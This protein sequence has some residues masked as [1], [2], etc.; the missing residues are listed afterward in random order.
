MDYT[1]PP[2]GLSALLHVPAWWKAPRSLY[3]SCSALGPPGPT[4]LLDGGTH[5]PASPAA[6]LTQVQ[7]H[8]LHGLVLL[9][10]QVAVYAQA[11][12][13]G[14]HLLR[15][16]QWTLCGEATPLSLSLHS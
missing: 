15:V 7:Q 9:H 5:H 1:T 8:G 2:T 10:H 16:V 6:P 12:H 13:N 3:L 14:Q 11:M 4:L